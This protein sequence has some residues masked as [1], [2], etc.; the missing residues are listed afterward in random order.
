MATK[1]NKKDQNTDK[2]QES[3]DNEDVVFEEENVEITGFGFSKD[4]KTKKLKEKLD[5]CLKES[6]ENLLGWQ[7]SRADFINAKKEN[8]ERVKQSFVFA[9]R[10]LIEDILPV[11]D[12]FEMAFS[13]KE[14]WENID[15]GWRT[16]VEYIYTQLLSI[17]E[18]NGLKPINSI[19]EKFNPNFHTSV[20]MVDTKNKKEDDIV[21]EVIQKGYEM[22]GGVI[23]AARV[24][25]GRF[26]E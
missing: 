24:K 1:K 20:E 12:S 10:E 7:R 11:V 18:S 16:G 8:E 5:K 19:G 26:K 23:R 25:V 15:N 2:Q 14:A 9:K 13:N 22:N 17:L 21:V 4:E 6:K 3:K